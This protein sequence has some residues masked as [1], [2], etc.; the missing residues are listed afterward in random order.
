[1]QELMRKLREGTITEEE[2]KKLMELMDKNGE[3][4]S[5]EDLKIMRDTRK[6]YGLLT[7]EELEMDE[8]EE[9]KRKLMS[10]EIT[11]EELKRLMELSNKY[12][13]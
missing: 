12:G 11:E 2:L 3:Q 8:L 7:L 13:V 6:K 1:M 9:L 4:M 10:G 5:E